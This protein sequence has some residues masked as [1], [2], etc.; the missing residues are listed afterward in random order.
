[1]DTDKI[2]LIVGLLTV[3]IG[4][5]LAQAYLLAYKVPPTKRV[6]R[7]WVSGCYEWRD[8]VEMWVT[9]NYIETEE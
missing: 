2:L 8:D 1:M 3:A 9:R 5:I 7:S 4:L 6:V